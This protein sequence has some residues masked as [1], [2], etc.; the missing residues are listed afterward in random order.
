MESSHNQN[1]SNIK[2]PP[3]RF[4]CDNNKSRHFLADCNKF[5]S[6]TPHQKRRTVVDAD[7]SE[8]CLS[9]GHIAREC[10]QPSKCRQ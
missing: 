4:V 6:F 3:F 1:Y 8:N 5:N 7:R 2:L 10:K 9:R